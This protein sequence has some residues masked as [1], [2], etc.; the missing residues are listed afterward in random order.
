MKVIESYVVKATMKS[1]DICALLHHC[2]GGRYYLV[3]WD[4][5]FDRLQW[6][7]VDSITAA[8]LIQGGKSL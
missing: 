2:E 3:E 8:D 6:R 4:R 5:D 1:P 7:E